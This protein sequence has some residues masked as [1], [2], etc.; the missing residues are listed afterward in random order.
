MNI[1]KYI[2]IRLVFQKNIPQKFLKISPMRIITWNLANET[3]GGNINPK[4]E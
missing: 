4:I 1:S 3:R 2:D